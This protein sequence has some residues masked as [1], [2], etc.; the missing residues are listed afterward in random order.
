MPAG[1][2]PLGRVVGGAVAGIGGALALAPM[3]VVERRLLGRRPAFDLL[4]VTRRLGAR[5][6]G[7]R[8]RRRLVSGAEWL[9]RLGYGASLGA[10][11]SVAR[12]GTVMGSCVIAGLE[13]LAMPAAG[14]TPPVNIW[15]RRERWLLVGHVAV[16][17]MVSRGLLRM[18][19][20][21]SSQ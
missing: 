10:L 6:L 21:G 15:S 19:G 2:R 4:L 5:V 12:L 9:L 18:G 7:R 13:M 14:A 16:F 3:D 17:V 20:V 1:E 11:L 8:P